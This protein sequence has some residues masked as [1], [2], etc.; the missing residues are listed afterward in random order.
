MSSTPI[1]RQMRRTVPNRLPS[2]GIECPAGRS[3]SSAGPPWR[4]T[5]SQISVI[6]SRGETSAA[7]RFNSPMPLELGEKIAQ[8]G[9]VHA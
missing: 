3:N 5:R 2:T 7:T 1:A 4:S 9:V 8:V 6:S